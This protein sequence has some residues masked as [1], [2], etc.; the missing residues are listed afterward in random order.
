MNKASHV[1]R[2]YSTAVNI[3]SA[4]IV[5]LFVFYYN[6][7]K[8]SLALTA[9]NSRQKPARHVLWVGYI[10]FRAT[11]KTLACNINI[12]WAILLRLDFDELKHTVPGFD[13]LEESSRGLADLL[14]KENGQK[15]QLQQ[16]SVGFSSHML[17]NGLPHHRPRQNNFGHNLPPGECYSLYVPVFA[18]IDV[19]M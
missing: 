4:K 11:T 1:A 7:K 6:L 3:F 17:F 13:P 18:L 19:V 8:V 9:T 14:E 5:F 10:K 12:L 16:N 2:Q 15:Q